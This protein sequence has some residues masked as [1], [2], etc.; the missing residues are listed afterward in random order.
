[1]YDFFTFPLY[2]AAQRPWVQ[3]AAAKRVRAYPVDSS[4]T[5]ITYQPTYKTCDGLERFKAAGIDTMDKCFEFALQQHS[6][7]R[8][9]G[10]RT[11]LSEEDEEQSN[12]KV[13]CRCCC[14]FRGVSPG[15]FH[16]IYWLLLEATTTE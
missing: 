6:H 2:L 10:T 16:M 11:V 8:M 1:M 4:D 12:G 7:N 13:K 3:T 15:H 14:G 5:E 9:V